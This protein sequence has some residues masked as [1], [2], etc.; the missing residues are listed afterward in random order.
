[1]NKYNVILK[2]YENKYAIPQF[3]IIDAE[4]ARYILEECEEEKSPVILG[5]SE[6]VANHLGGFKVARNIVDGLIDDLNITVPV[7]LHLDHAKSKESCEKAI[8]AGF[9]SVMLD[10]SSH[11]LEENIKLTKSLVQQNPNTIIECEVGTIGK[12]GNEGIIYSDIE[13]IIRLKKETN[14]HL[15]APSFGTVHGVYKGEPKL[16]FELLDEIKEKIDTPLVMHGGSGLSEE[17][18]K[19]SISR[20]ISKININTELKHAWTKAIRKYLSENP[21]ETDPVYIIESVSSEI[22]KVVSNL[23]NIFGSNNKA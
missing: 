3:N 16:N 6:K 21:D 18:F 11:P 13:D 22:K 7:I 20:G 2:A 12:N 5:V 15:I 9:D 4:Y 14:A 1:M 8:K 19:M 10:Y 23:I 17:N